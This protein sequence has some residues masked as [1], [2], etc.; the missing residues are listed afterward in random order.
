MF[1]KAAIKF[2]A[3]VLASR[4]A[5]PLFLILLIAC[6]PSEKAQFGNRP[7]PPNQTLPFVLPE[8]VY[9]PP[10]IQSLKLHPV[11]NPAAPPVITLNGS[12]K[13]T[14]SFDHLSNEAQQFRI[15]ISHHNQD[16]Q[17]SSLPPTAYTAAFFETYFGGGVSGFASTPSYRHYEYSFSNE[18]IDIIKSGNY[19]LSVYNYDTDEL[20]FRIPFFVSENRG[21]LQT[22]IQ[23]A[24]ARDVNAGSGVQLFTDYQYPA[25]VTQ[26][27]FDLSAV[28]V[29]EQFW[30]RTRI[31]ENGFY[32][33]RGL[34][35]FRLR[36]SMAFT[37]DYSLN[38]ID[39]R[40]YPSQ[41]NEISDFIPAEEPPVVILERDVQPFS[42]VGTFYDNVAFGPLHD[43]QSR[44]LSVR[45]RFEPAENI[46]PSADL[47]LIGT[48]TNWTIE[49]RFRMHL[50]VS[51]SLW[52]AD[53]LLKQGIYAYKYVLVKNGRIESISSYQ[54]FNNRA[55]YY[56]TFIYYTDPEL[57]YDRLLKVGRTEN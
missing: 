47:Y 14:L 55:Q 40:E 27:Q 6:K 23:T 52:V 34:I 25:F 4:R 11:G 24:F 33:G 51:D 46:L 20:L 18:R 26:P 32:A 30:G 41:G 36:R 19:L 31:V 29:P 49:E 56:L 15:S 48:F 13:L 54:G 35:E 43:R 10:A 50:D 57:L 12:R 16:W 5:L 28:Y 42:T 53:A 21:R 17:K 45:F 1:M 38:I 44:Y 39:L 7:F 22:R 2:K 8:A 37:D 9:P 3:I